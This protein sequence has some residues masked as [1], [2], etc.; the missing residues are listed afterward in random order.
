[1]LWAFLLPA[2][3]F[4]LWRSHPKLTGWAPAEALGDRGADTALNG[5]AGPGA[6]L[7][8][9][10]IRGLCWAAEG[11]RRCWLSRDEGGRRSRGGFVAPWRGSLRLSRAYRDAQ[12]L[13]DL[14]PNQIVPL[15]C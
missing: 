10:E 9:A 7:V 13:F 12:D 6:V 5:E 11:A 3:P 4:T 2:T 14:L 15:H 8:S 1:M